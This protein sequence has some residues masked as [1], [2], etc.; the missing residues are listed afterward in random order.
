MRIY[1]GLENIHSVIDRHEAEWRKDH[2]EEPERSRLPSLEESVRR[3][4]TAQQGEGSGRFAADRFLGAAAKPVNLKK[5]P[6]PEPEP[7]NVEPETVNVEPE[8]ASHSWLYNEVMKAVKG[9]S[10]GN[11]KIVAVFVP[12]IQNEGE[13]R[14]IPA[15]DDEADYDGE[16]VS[17]VEIIR[18]KDGRHSRLYDEVMRA[19]NDAAGDSRK[20]TAVFVPLLQD[21][22]EF[23]DIPADETVTLSPVSEDSVKAE[24]AETVPEIPKIE[25]EIA[26]EAGITAETEAM[27]IVPVPEVIL[28]PV[29]EAELEPVPESEP[30]NEQESAGDFDL[31]PE[32][33]VE[34]DSELAEAFREMEEKLDEDTAEEQVQEIPETEPEQA[35]EIVPEPEPEETP[36]I[37]QEPEPEYVPEIVPEIE[38][39]T[40]GND[41]DDEDD[42]TLPDGEP[43]EFEEIDGIGG[44]NNSD[45]EELLLPDTLDDDEILDDE[46]FDETLTEV[47][48]PDDDDETIIIEGD[49][50]IEIIPDPVN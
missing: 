35:L 9:A 37:P 3:R 43:M 33:Q 44:D 21:G 49:D 22:R 26:Q 34:S 47:H 32:G 30:E 19:V 10:D 48:R 24:P 18:N 39:V 41:Y 23:E 14:D 25:P 15:G 50:E 5:P 13:A 20:I 17:A 42:E 36:E 8:T 27:L 16:N 28:E 38:P 31:I 6:M 1:R 46:E 4:L 40:A 11:A 29:Q 7:V 2:G 12:V 45:G